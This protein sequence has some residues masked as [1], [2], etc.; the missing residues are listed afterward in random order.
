MKIGY[1][2]LRYIKISFDS[3]ENLESCFLA[4]KLLIGK[5]CNFFFFCQITKDLNRK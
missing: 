4:S 1:L 3:A 2:T 5:F